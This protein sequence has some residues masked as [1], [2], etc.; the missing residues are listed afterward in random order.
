[1]A[2]ALL[3]RSSVAFTMDAYRHVVH[4]RTDQAA[5]ALEGRSGQVLRV[6]NQTSENRGVGKL[7]PTR[8]G[9]APKGAKSGPPARVSLFCYAPGT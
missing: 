7:L 4:D 3:G 8:R 5:T 1:M 2:S 9:L 6:A